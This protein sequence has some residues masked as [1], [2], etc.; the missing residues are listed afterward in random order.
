[1]DYFEIRARHKDGSYRWLGWT[2]APFLSEKLIYI[3]GRDVTRRREAE[4]KV[5]ELNAQLQHQ[6]EALT[7]VNQELEAFNYSISHD[8]RAPLRSMQSF[9]QILLDDHVAGLSKEGA[10]LAARIVRSS[11]YLDRLL[12]DLLTYSRLTNAE[13]PRVPVSLDDILSQVLAMLDKDTKD[14]A[15]VFDV[16]RPLGCVLGHP[17]TVTQIMAN[18]VGN[19]LKFVP[20]DRAPRVRISSSRTGDMVRFSVQDNG[21]GIEPEHHRKIF[22][23]F[24]RLHSAQDYP[25]TGIGLALVRKG[26]ERLGGRVGLSSEPSQG[27]L[28]WVDLPAAADAPP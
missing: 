3:F 10:E 15:A 7:E 6:V 24:E 23:L 5:Q 4:S 28:F 11:H 1:V 8:L 17:A 2:A 18:L 27:S 20:A 14:K 12:C 21:I 16:T 25:G 13:L 22:G 26:A 19:A 9:A